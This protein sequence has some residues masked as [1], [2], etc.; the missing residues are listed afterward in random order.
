MTPFYA[1]KSKPSGWGKA[2]PGCSRAKSSCW[3]GLALLALFVFSLAFFLCPS[4]LLAA[5]I[6]PEQ[7][8][9]SLQAGSGSSWFIDMG[10]YQQSAHSDLDC[11]KCH[12]QMRDSDSKHPD[13][14]DPNFLQLNSIT[15]FDYTACRECHPRAYARYNQGLHARARQKQA[16]WTDYL[17]PPRERAAPQE[18]KLLQDTPPTCGH[19]H[20]VHT[21][22]SSQTR[23]ELGKSQMQ[24]CGPCH[25]EF[26][27]S[28][29]KNIHGKIAVNLENADAAYC[30][31]CHGAHQVIDLDDEQQNLKACRRC[32]PQANASFTEAIIHSTP[33]ALELLGQEHEDL[34]WKTS[35]V[36][37]VR[38][39]VIIAVILFII[40][41]AGH[42]L[43]SYLREAHEKLR[44]K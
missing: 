11:E 9:S 43:L 37:V 23:V 15:S 7:T 26:E 28:Y 41:F 30:T 20:N 19:C 31:D 17:L 12:Y 5:H 22:P 8:D 2:G 4:S 38:T 34:R 36:S 13:F 16:L 18:P 25:R 42:T 14:S 33:A 32:H 21:Q 24:I 6:V 3:P 35:F 39:L 10:E 40:F 44:K 1:I 27:Q 29:Q